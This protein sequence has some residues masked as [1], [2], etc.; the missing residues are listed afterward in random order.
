MK[1]LL[2]AATLGL[3]TFAQAGD[4]TGEWLCRIEMNRNDITVKSEL[5][6]HFYEDG[7]MMIEN[8]STY[9]FGGRQ[10]NTETFSRSDGEYKLADDKLTLIYGESELIRAFEIVPETAEKVAAEVPEDQV[11]IPAGY[12]ETQTFRFDGSRIFFVGQPPNDLKCFKQNV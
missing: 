12:Q 4:L 5:R 3:A 2:L 8:D 11:L 1:K 10:P 7:T 6:Y 9:Y